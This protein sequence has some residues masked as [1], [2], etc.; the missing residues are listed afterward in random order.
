MYFPQILILLGLIKILDQETP[1][2]MC[3]GVYSAVAVVF[4]LFTIKTF[5]FLTLL[6]SA[7]IIFCMSF[8]YF[9]VLDKLRGTGLIRGIVAVVGALLGF[10]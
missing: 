6:I 5:D 4:R 9:W 8:V 7:V 3:A 2:L 10:V 1:P